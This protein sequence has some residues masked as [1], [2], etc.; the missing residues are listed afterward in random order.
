MSLSYRVHQSSPAKSGPPPDIP[1]KPQP[2]PPPRWLHF[3]WL[4]GL[5]VTLGLLFIPGGSTSSPTS[6]TYSAWR[7]DVDANQVKTGLARVVPHPGQPRESLAGVIDR[8]QV[9]GRV[10][11]P[12]VEVLLAELLR[13]VDPSVRAGHIVAQRLVQQ[14]QAVFVHGV[15]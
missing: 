11:T 10:E 9:R 12:F 3:L 4:I 14:P 2:N 5:V 1:P 15:R 6:L 7:T 13:V 8:D